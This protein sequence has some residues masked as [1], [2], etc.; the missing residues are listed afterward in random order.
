MQVDPI[1]CV[2][3][4]SLYEYVSSNPNNWID[5]LGLLRYW[6]QWGGPNWTGGQCELYENLSEEEQGG[7]KEPE[8]SMDECFK[9][10]DLDFSKC[11]VKRE[12]NKCKYGEEKATENYNK[13]I[14]RTNKKLDKCLKRLPKDPRKWPK[15]PQK[16]KERTARI[17]RWCSIMIF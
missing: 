4:M 5:P 13:C 8:D 15:P 14:E 11:R 16:G 17:K 9:Q 3:G 6:G 1:G 12:K 2:N 7:L 10:H